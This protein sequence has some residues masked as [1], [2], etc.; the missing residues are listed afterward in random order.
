MAFTVAVA[1]PP[2]PIA[3]VPAAD[4]T[5]A[6]APKWR[7]S[8]GEH[9]HLLRWTLI[10][11]LVAGDLALIV[12]NVDGD[13]LSLAA[14]RWNW[15]GAAIAAEALSLLT[16]ARLRRR[17]LRAGG[18]DVS[19]GRMGVLTLASSALSCT[20]PAGTAV[21][22]GYLFRQ[23]RRLGGSAPLVAW[24]IVTGT[25]VSVL[26]FSVL[27]MAGTVLAGDSSLGAVVGAG[28]LS[29]VAVL[30]LVAALTVVTRHPLPLVR[31]GARVA[32]RLPVL[33][34]RTWDAADVE[35][36]ADQVGAITPRVRDWSAAFWFALA[37]WAADF[38][39]F[40]LCCYAVGVHGLGVGAAVLAYVAGLA[41]TSVS[42]LP[43]GLGSMEAGMLVGL[44][45]A[46]VAAPL[47]V[48]G[49]L[50]YRVVAYG[51]VAAVG[52]LAWLGL[53]RTT[54]TPVSV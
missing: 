26:A 54:P 35:R 30:A 34:R 23:L 40:M 7:W 44:A 17:L 6:A 9:R 13:A 39:C 51:L 29:L 19:L 4:P 21:S 2:A 24:T 5:T 27:T 25:V 49:V 32:R 47:A 48:A 14:I 50:A 53:R 11:A 36:I 42:L 38:A 46:G 52:W 37:N 43:G 20:V 10:A 16:F 18:F 28:G 1:L 45:N 33:R 8:A 41:T 12:P 3:A 15:L 31:A 22:A